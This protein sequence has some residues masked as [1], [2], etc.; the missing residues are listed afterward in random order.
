MLM[1]QRK[2][3]GLS[4]FRLVGI[5]VQPST[6]RLFG[7][8][9]RASN[10]N[11][12]FE[13]NPA[14][15]AATA[16]GSPISLPTA[17]YFSGFCFD[18][19]RGEIRLVNS[20]GTNYR[21][22]PATG[23]LLG[24]DTSISYAANDPNAGQ[25]ASIHS[26][27]FS[28]NRA[29]SQNARLYGLDHAGSRLVALDTPGSGTLRTVGNLGVDLTLGGTASALGIGTDANGLNSFYLLRTELGAVQG[30]TFGIPA[31]YSVNAVTG[32]A[33]LLGQIQSSQYIFDLAV[34]NNTVVS[35]THDRLDLAQ[36][37][38]V[39]PNPARGS[40]SLQ[41]NLPK[42]GHTALTVCDNLGRTVATVPATLLSGANSLRW[43]AGAA[44]P[45]L[46]LLRLAVDGQPVATR[47]VVLE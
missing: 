21:L 37:I 24:T 9:F 3:T 14:T 4:E 38:T 32:Q 17:A 35:A 11:Q 29:G 43:N 36:N 27:S 2:V 31:L 23:A 25:P 40:A 13:L 7:L 20:N 46:Y 47:R 15:G 28:N 39:A 26:L 44:R 18:P 5:E 1:R 16:I 41:F 19:A 6:E 30:G 45:G 22:D 33:T 8:G 12:L 42:A 10:Q 34:A